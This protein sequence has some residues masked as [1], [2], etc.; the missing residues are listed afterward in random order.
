MKSGSGKR[1]SKI[2]PN[3]KLSKISQVVKIWQKFQFLNKVDFFGH[4]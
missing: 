1:A 2:Q 4:I 3:K